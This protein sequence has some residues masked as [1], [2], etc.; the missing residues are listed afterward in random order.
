MLVYYNIYVKKMNTF[1]TNLKTNTTMLKHKF[2]FSSFLV[3]SLL[4]FISISC[5][6]EDDAFTEQELPPGAQKTFEY[7]T[8]V[9]GYNPD[10]LEVDFSTESF[11][12]NN[13][14]AI[15]FDTKANIDK[16]TPNIEKED[17]EKNQWIGSSGVSYENSRRITYYY[18]NNFPDEYKNAF[19]WAAYHWSRVS[20]NINFNRT[21]NRN[22][23][24]V[25]VSS[26][27]DSGD[28]AWARAQLPRRDGY[29]G[30][31]VALN[32]ATA[33]PTN[34]SETTKMTLM[35]H[36][37]GHTLGFHHS[38]QNL[39]IPIPGTRDY[40]YHQRENCGSIMKSSVYNCN[41]VSGSSRAAWTSDDWTSIH[42]AYRL[43]P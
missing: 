22:T 13:D 7:L 28:S 18:E 23:A 41:W 6:K 27:Y 20:P 39:G 42:W 32:R 31:W 26:Y 33:L 12:F 4:C 3:V 17:S 10:F 35:I 21:T 43:Y 2:T 16:Y 37:L 24:H 29:T 9:E 38:D 1:R 8:E 36:E 40:R 30:T 25:L 15:S 19:S 11:I 5:Q 14:I 34:P